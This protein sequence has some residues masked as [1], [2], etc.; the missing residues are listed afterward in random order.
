M[1][2]FKCSTSHL[3]IQVSVVSALLLH[4]QVQ[5]QEWARVISSV[6][7]YQ[8]VAVD[9]PVCADTAVETQQPNSGVGAVVGAIAGGLFGSGLANS[10]GGSGAAG[11]A[12]GALGGALLGDKAES[13]SNPTKLRTVRQCQHQI[14][15]ENRVNSYQVIYEYG[16]KQFNAIMPY[17]PGQYLQIQITPVLPPPVAVRVTVPPPMPPP[18]LPATMPLQ[19]VPIPQPGG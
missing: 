8:A 14:T 7:I 4:L 19:I 17:P 16:G 2:N 18:V 11:A 10:S 3:V 1:K 6:P 5:A 12:L 9:R 13:H 15:H